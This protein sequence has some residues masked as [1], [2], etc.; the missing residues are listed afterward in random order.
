MNANL[1]TSLRRGF[2]LVEILIVVVILGILAAIVVPQFADASTMAVK[3]ALLRQLQSIDNQV[4]LYRGA[5]AGQFPTADPVAP[6]AAGGTNNGWGALVSDQYLKESPLNPFTSMTLLVAGD[7][8]TAAAE[9]NSSVNGWY[10]QLSASADRL[11]IFAA[12]YDRTT[13][14][15]SNEP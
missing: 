11:D 4:E 13:D 8:A 10:F 14:R 5:H 6:M 2:T 9:L 1:R 15:L 7:G 12:G 3:S